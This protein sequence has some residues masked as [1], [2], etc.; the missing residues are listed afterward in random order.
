MRRLPHDAECFQLQH[1]LVSSH[2]EIL[3]CHRRSNCCEF[4]CWE[5]S[6]YWQHSVTITCIVLVLPQEARPNLLLW[7]SKRWYSKA[8]TLR[9]LSAILLFPLGRH[10]CLKV[11]LCRSVH[12][13][14]YEQNGIWDAKWP[15]F[16]DLGRPILYIHERRHMAKFLRIRRSKHATC[17]YLSH[18]TPKVC[19]TNIVPVLY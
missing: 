11:L 15:C 12:P 4:L 7:W 3:H 19:H 14:G 16:I 13:K 5:A 1:C 6:C 2:S 9:Y 8:S 10:P 18:S 17:C